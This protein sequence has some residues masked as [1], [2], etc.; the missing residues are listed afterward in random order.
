MFAQPVNDLPVWQRFKDG[1]WRSYGADASNIESAFQSN[2]G[3]TSLTTNGVIIDFLSMI[4]TS[5]NAPT[6][7][8]R[9]SSKENPD[10]IYEW[11]ENA[12]FG[13]S[14]WT[15]YSTDD[16]E[17]LNICERVGRLKIVLYIANANLPYEIDLNARTQINSQTQFRRWIRKAP[18]LAYSASPAAVAPNMRV[19]F[20]PVIDFNGN[21]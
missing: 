1:A 16:C 7:I 11:Q 2:Q 12:F 3:S 17:A 14:I 6:P 10:V 5:R 4:E 9:L 18:L 20:L 13:R 19:T 21:Q 15:T 8:R